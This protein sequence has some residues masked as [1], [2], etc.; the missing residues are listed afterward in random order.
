MSVFLSVCLS[1]Y[2]YLSVWDI[3]ILNYLIKY[4][5]LVTSERN[6]HRKK[7]VRDSAR[8]DLRY[9]SRHYDPVISHPLKTF[10]FLSTVLS[11][12]SGL[13]SDYPTLVPCLSLLDNAVSPSPIMKIFY[14]CTFC[15]YYVFRTDWSDCVSCFV[16]F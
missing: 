16:L 9:V 5:F 15:P 1:F 14:K 11:T 8:R 13:D 7:I 4:E 6:W 3:I 12:R 2:F 10:I